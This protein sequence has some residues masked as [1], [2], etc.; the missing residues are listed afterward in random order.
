MREMLRQAELTLI[1]FNRT[2]QDTP[3]FVEGLKDFVTNNYGP[4]LAGAM[5]SVQNDKEAQGHSFDILD[6]IK[7]N[8]GEEEVVV[9]K[10]GFKTY[11]KNNNMRFLNPDTFEV[12]KKMDDAGK[13]YG[14][15]TTGSEESQTFQLEVSGV[16]DVPHHIVPRSDK[17]RMIAEEW[18]QDDGSFT[19][20]PKFATDLG[21]RT[22]KSLLLADDKASAF[23]DLP[24]GVWRD[25]V[26]LGAWGNHYIDMRYGVLPSQAGFLPENAVPISS[27]LEMGIPAEE[28]KETV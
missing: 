27:L 7:K 4:D 8:V 2:I 3:G 21:K 16:S 10:E 25:G 15:L 24:E 26:P 13:T 20:P 18:L 9:F 28:V 12:F 17:G 6:F 22:F 5:K 23:A 19:V 1:D 14:I 11:C